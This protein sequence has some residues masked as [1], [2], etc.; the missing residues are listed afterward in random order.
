MVIFQWSMVNFFGGAAAGR[1]GDGLTDCL[2]LDLALGAQK[3]CGGVSLRG[4][5][6]DSG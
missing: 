6:V 2:T 3:L 1:V 5:G 4:G